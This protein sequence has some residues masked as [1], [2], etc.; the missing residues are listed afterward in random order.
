[1]R[2]IMIFQ[3]TCL[4]GRRKVWKSGGARSTVVGII[5]PPGLD[6]VNCLAKNWGAKAPPAPH[7]RRACSAVYFEKQ[8]SFIPKRKYDLSR[9]L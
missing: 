3:S 4:Q 9:S 6:R 1:M 5:C 8:K 7:L 2:W